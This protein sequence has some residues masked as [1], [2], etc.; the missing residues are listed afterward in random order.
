MT[1]LGK[2]IQVSGSQ[3]WDGSK[4][5]G[6][7]L[8]DFATRAKGRDDFDH[9]ITSQWDVTIEEFANL[10][11]FANGAVTSSLPTGNGVLLLTTAPGGDNR[12]DMSR[13]GTGMSMGVGQPIYTEWRFTTPQ[14]SDQFG[15][16]QGIT[17]PGRTSGPFVVFGQVNIGAGLN[18]Y[19]A[20]SSSTGLTASLFAMPALTGNTYKAKLTVGQAGASLDMAVDDAAYTSVATLPAAPEGIAYIPYLSTFSGN[21][22]ERS[23]A[24]DYVE[25][26][27]ARAAT[28]GADL[29]PVPYRVEI[30]STSGG[31][32]NTTLSIGSVIIDDTTTL[33]D[34]PSLIMIESTGA[35]ASLVIP[36][37]LDTGPRWWYIRTRENGGFHT[38]LTWDSPV[39]VNGTIGPSTLQISDV[40]DSLWIL[41]RVG[42]TEYFAHKVGS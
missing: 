28:D 14:G 29:G 42:E 10:S 12:I 19:L 5:I 23:L 4:F 33:A 21:A 25:W 41:I 17:G 37:G 6:T 9:D 11:L 38:D 3:V 40:A 2:P 15:W 30:T 7:R 35:D 34:S 39:V 8:D 27:S 20:M 32:S 16:L 24:V 26:D 13:K 1:F 31:T 22:V 36:S 18:H